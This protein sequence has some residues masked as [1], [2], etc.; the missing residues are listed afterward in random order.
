M[1]FE[2][3]FA[4]GM[5]SDRQKRE[6]EIERLLRGESVRREPDLAFQEKVREAAS[7]IIQEDADRTEKRER[8][9]RRRLALGPRNPGLWILLAGAAL[10]FAMPF[11]G[12]LL[13]LGGIAALLWSLRSR[14]R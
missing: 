7:A 13:L 6:E 8:A 14:S 4:D 12:G 9:T 10:S 11:L 2:T 5:K 1:I 3:L